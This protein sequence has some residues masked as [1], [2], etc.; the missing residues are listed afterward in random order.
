MRFV[1]LRFD[2]LVLGDLNCFYFCFFDSRVFSNG[3][4]TVLVNNAGLAGDLE[5]TK[6]SATWYPLFHAGLLVHNEALVSAVDSTCMAFVE[7]PN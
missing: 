7:L 1:G 2:I 4:V 3:V 5:E 6:H